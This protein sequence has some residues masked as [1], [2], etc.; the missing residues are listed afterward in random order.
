MIA[1]EIAAVLLLIVL[2]GLFAMSELAVVSARKSRLQALAE[3]GNRRAQAAIRL[4]DDPA[5]FLSTVQIGITLIGVLSGALSGATVADRLGDWL[6]GWPG[7]APYGDTIAIGVVVVVLTYLSLIVGELVPKR[8]ALGSPE[9]IAAA[10]APAMQRIARVA[11]PAVFLLKVSTDGVLA[12]LGLRGKPES[13]VTEDEVRMLIAE[14]ARSGVFEAKEREMLE[15]VL[16]L[17]DRRVPAIMTPRAEVVWLD[18]AADAKAIAARL[19]E[20]RLSRYPVCRGSLD[21]PVGIVQMKD[22][23]PVLLEQR[24]IVLAEHMAPALI[25]PESILVLKLLESFRTE[26]MHMAIVVDEYG[27]TQGVVTLADILESITGELPER[28]EE[29]ELEITMREDG[30]WLVDGA[31]PVDEFE[32]RVG[33]RGVR[34]SGDF[35]TMAGFV[36]QQ[37]GRLPTVGDSFVAFGGRFEIVDMDGHRID[38]I[39]FVP[40]RFGPEMDAG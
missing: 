4:I 21:Q 19:A 17:A 39:L 28:G 10:V 7:I 34:D 15:A 18:E 26:G 36:L 23:V 29:L 20:R 8:I 16:R 27:T 30:S 6:D 40:D 32:H 5:T 14:G 1:I 38:K 31:V 11:R 9:T 13:R 22:L 3:G 12:F 2:N 33:I 24:P 35:E 37:M 25:V